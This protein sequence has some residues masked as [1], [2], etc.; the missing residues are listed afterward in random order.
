[1]T[2]FARMEHYLGAEYHQTCVSSKQPH[3]F[4]D[5]GYF[6]MVQPFKGPFYRSK[7]IGT[8]NKN[9]M[10]NYNCVENDDSSLSIQFLDIFTRTSNPSVD[11]V[12]IKNVIQK[13]LVF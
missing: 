12:R 4:T 8:D 13:F 5:P 2:F 1:M 9:F 6:E 3:V 11:I 10:A 7:V